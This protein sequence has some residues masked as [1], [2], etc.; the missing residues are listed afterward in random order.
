MQLNLDSLLSSKDFK[1]L[2]LA[3]LE[4]FSFYV[5]KN[6]QEKASDFENLQEGLKRLNCKGFF[7]FIKDM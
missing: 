4:I 1:L 5:R 2:E 3:L 7:A 6:V